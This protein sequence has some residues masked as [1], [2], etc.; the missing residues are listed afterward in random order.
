VKAVWLE[1]TGAPL[2]IRE[3][4]D[5][6]ITPSGVVVRVLA[7]RVPS[8]TRRVFDGTLGYDL[9]TPLIPGPACIGQV[10]CVGQD[11]F[12]VA[13]GDVVLC[14]SFLSSGDLTRS[15]DE[16]LIAWTGTGSERSLSMQKLWRHG[17]YAELALYPARCLTVL[18]EGTQFE[19]TLLP[20]LASLAI[21]DGGLQRGGLEAGQVVV[22]NGA[23]GQLGGA[24]VLLA[25]ARGAARVVATGRN[26]KRLKTLAEINRRVMI[27]GLR[28]DRE[29]DAI[30]IRYLAN[31][32]IDLVVDYLADTQTPD[33]TLAGFDVL[34]LGGTMILVGG[35]RHALALPYAQIMRRQLTIRGSFM[36]DR[37]GALQAWNLVRSGAVDLS[38]V[39]AFSFPLQDMEQAI[40]MAMTLGGL[41]YA[42]LL[43]N[44]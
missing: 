27:H 31:G 2:E 39:R 36:F 42:L 35:V 9:P 10:E 8:Y 12:D 20:F 23:T 44:G 7:V 22:I 18:P 26:E 34:R 37:P 19:R 25:L 4:P 28:G 38:K 32:P 40:D 1:A 33:P 15:P 29:Q 14:N 43:P 3:V 24:A 41:D 13:V 16:I 5:P 21:A 17:S 30:S 11:V 6:V